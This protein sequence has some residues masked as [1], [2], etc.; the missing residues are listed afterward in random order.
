M[1]QD[2]V[3]V[4]Q[5]TTSWPSTF[6]TSFMIKYAWLSAIVSD[7]TC[8]VCQVRCVQVYGQNVMFWCC[9]NILVPHGTALASFWWCMIVFSISIAALS[10][11]AACHFHNKCCN[12]SFRPMLGKE[13]MMPSVIKDV[14]DPV[15]LL[16]V[17]RWACTLMISTLQP[18]QIKIM[19]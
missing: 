1:H 11:S 13:L 4:Y 3:N 7:E 15:N 18:N 6:D 5:V 8:L 12:I 16:T 10:K 9:G 17:K 19:P 14:M 2:S